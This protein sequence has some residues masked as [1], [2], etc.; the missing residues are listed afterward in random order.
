[1]I[2]FSFARFYAM[3]RK[4][5]LQMKRD[6]P[7]MAMTVALPI[8]QLTLFGTAINTNPRH[9]P[10]AV[11]SA[12]HSRYERSITSAFANTSYFDMLDYRSERDADHA[13]ARGDVLFVLR[14]PPAFARQVDRGEHPQILLQSDATDPVAIGPASAAVGAV[15]PHV[16]DRDLPPAL[17][18]VPVAAPFSV[19]FQNR[20]NPEQITALNVVPGLIGV[21][22]SFSTMIA[23]TLSI[24][25]EREM[26]TMENLLSMPIRPTEVMLGKIVPYVG[27]GYV[28]TSLILFV[29]VT[30]F[31][32]PI[33][34]SLPLLLGSLGIFIACNLAL[35]F[36]FSSLA[37]TQMQAQQMATFALLPSMLLSGFLFPFAGMPVWARSIGQVLPLTHILRIC[38]GILLKGNGL[39]EVFPDLWPMALFALAIGTLA[40]RSYRR[41]LD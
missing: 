22:L 24:T 5:W 13:L 23:T 19:T 14:I 17:R 4:E 18:G 6:R 33:L 35:G 30:A 28:Q 10:T 32:V 8:V 34:G 31:R 3:L 21:I 20:F 11:L 1:M 41:T 29:A 7:L 26:G 25:R 38:R 39:A 2:G 37:K 12:D 9:L 15:T 36:T 16:L 27:L 40:V